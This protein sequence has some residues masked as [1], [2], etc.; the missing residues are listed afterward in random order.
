MNDCSN[1][2]LSALRNNKFIEGCY[3]GLVVA[4]ENPWELAIDLVWQDVGK[5][6]ISP[7]TLSDFWALREWWDS[8]LTHHSKYLFFL[9]PDNEKKDRYIANH[10]KVH[11][12]EA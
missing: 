10:K 5:L 1:E 7:L 11:I 3:D 4:G 12:T 6:R 9:F 2:I 8:S